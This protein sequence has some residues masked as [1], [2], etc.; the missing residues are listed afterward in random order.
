M[1]YIKWVCELTSKDQL[2]SN[3]HFSLASGMCLMNERKKNGLKMCI[4]SNC[5]Y[6]I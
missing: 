6:S 1:G 3:T 5:D 2:I 4:L